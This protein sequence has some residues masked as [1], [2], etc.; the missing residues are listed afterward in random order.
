MNTSNQNH[1]SR[2]PHWQSEKMKTIIETRWEEVWTVVVS[3]D[4][5]VQNLHRYLTSPQHNSGF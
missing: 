1:R 3:R 2:L 4:C 5:S